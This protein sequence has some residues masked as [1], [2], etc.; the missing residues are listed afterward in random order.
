MSMR[1]MF[2]K[3]TVIFDWYKIHAME[4]IQTVLLLL[5]LTLSCTSKKKLQETP[6]S[7]EASASMRSHFG[8]PVT[9]LNYLSYEEAIA[10]YNTLKI[11]DTIALKFASSVSEV[12]AKKGCWMNLSENG[13]EEKVMVRFK[14]YGF[15]VPRDSEGSEVIVEGKAFLEKVSV[16]E[17]KHYAM[18]AGRSSDEITQIN[19]PKIEFSFEANGVLLK[20]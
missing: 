19:T 4:K 14:D 17:L 1:V 10:I 13:S 18:D 16:S 8:G 11:G 3:K 9:E 20:N 12:C 6:P 2:I 15:F 5:L 7:N